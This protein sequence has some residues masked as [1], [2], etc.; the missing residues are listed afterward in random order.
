ML[1]A[2]TTVA[3]TVDAPCPIPKAIERAHVAKPHVV[4]LDAYAVRPRRRGR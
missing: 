1:I 3:R 2:R 4:T